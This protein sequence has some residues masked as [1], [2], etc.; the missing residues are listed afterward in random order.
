MFHPGFSIDSCRWW[1][2]L[3]CFAICFGTADGAYA[4]SDR[5]FEVKY[6]QVDF[7]QSLVQV[8]GDNFKDRKFTPLSAKL[9]DV[10][11]ALTVQNDSRLTAAL[12]RG[13]EAGTY[14]LVFFKNKRWQ[15]DDEIAR[16]YVALAGS[17]AGPQGPKG[18]TGP[19][20]PQGEVGP[21]GLPG[22]DGVDGL[23]GPQGPS[24]MDGAPGPVGAP[25]PQGIPGPIGATGP[26]G[27][28]GPVGA[29]G[30]RGEMGPAGAT[31]PQGE[32]G[33]VG[34]TGPQ[35]EMGPVGATGPQGIPGPQGVPGP[36]GAMGPVGAA[37]PEGPVGATGATGAM[38]ATG[39]KGDKGDTGAAGPQGVAGPR[40][41]VGPQGPEGPPPNYILGTNYVPKDGSV[42]I[43]TTEPQ[44]ELDVRGAILAG[45]L[46]GPWDQS[47][48]GFVMLGDLQIAWGTFTSTST[49]PAAVTPLPASFASTN[50]QVTVSAAYLD[51]YRVAHVMAKTASTIT[52]Q[53]FHS[54]GTR[55]GAIGSYIAIG[56]W[57]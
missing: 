42:G 2:M 27:E 41:E 20:G 54:N 46:K 10:P 6:V 44:A 32:M 9:G 36:E 43:G 37:G 34:A 14:A 13:F 56:R 29:T 5:D 7:A 53:T 28:I 25:G 23:P 45:E 19:A 47:E 21:Q 30:P 49:G 1:G 18:D 48:N 57:R 38:G 39:P 55:S 33:P 26:Q 15:H 12:P 22:R 4:D 3:F 11:L 50:Y 8:Y 17:V 51:P 52:V 40:G 24:G 31:G 35:G 16:V